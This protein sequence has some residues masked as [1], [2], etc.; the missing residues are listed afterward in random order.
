MSVEE[1]KALGRRW[2]EKVNK[3]EVAAMEV[4]DE[5]F[6]PNFIFH[7]GTGE[8]IRGLDNFK[9]Q[10]RETFNAFPNIHFAIDDMI[11]EG[12]KLA[13]RW[14]MSCTHKGEVGVS[15]NNKKWKMWTISID[16]VA[17]GKFVEEWERY[18]T[19]GLMKQLGL[20]AQ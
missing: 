19:Q 1:I 8:D 20:I 17:G 4:I 14:T 18:D 3:G 7:S 11:V 13:V 9:K 10:L 16:R 5:I 12:D 2:F 6:S 15:P